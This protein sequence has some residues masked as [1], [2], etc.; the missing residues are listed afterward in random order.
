[1]QV[2]TLITW[3]ILFSLLVVGV[4]VTYKVESSSGYKQAL[5]RYFGSKQLSIKSS[6]L[7]P[8]SAEVSKRFPEYGIRLS[9]FVGATSEDFVR[10]FSVSYSRDSSVI[11]VHMMIV[12][13]AHVYRVIPESGSELE[14]ADFNS[15]ELRNRKG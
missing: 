1:M 14:A 6:Q 12:H 13:D 3:L 5:H 15:A 9:F 2:E 7:I 8:N 4:I 10:Y 11:Q